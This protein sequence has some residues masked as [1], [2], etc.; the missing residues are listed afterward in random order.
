MRYRTS[1][2]E[3]PLSKEK[4]K[5]LQAALDAIHQDAEQKRKER[6]INHGLQV[7]DKVVNTN[8]H[9]DIVKSSQPLVVTKVFP[10]KSSVEVLRDGVF[11]FMVN[12]GHLKKI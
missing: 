1:L 5:A 10:G 12:G 7:G 6:E 8:P 11:H 9:D 3:A 4:L 2:V